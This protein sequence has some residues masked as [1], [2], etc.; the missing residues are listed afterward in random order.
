MLEQ[1]RKQ[2]ASIFVYLI[3]CLLIAIFVI[4]FR[5]G[6]SRNDDSGCSGTSN[7][8]LSVDGTEST[9]TAFKMAYSSPYNYGT[10]KSKVFIALETL[11]RR[12]LLA[13][14]GEARGLM[15]NEDLIMEQIKKGRFF[16][17]TPPPLNSPADVEAVYRPIRKAIPGVFNADDGHWDLKAYKT[18][19][20]NLN[21]SQNAY[22]EEQRRSMLAS[23]MADILME[24]VQVSKE[25]ALAQFRYDNDTATYD[26]VSFKP[27]TYRTALRMTETDVDRYL[28]DHGDDVSARYK[29]DERTYKGTK[30]ALKLR[31]IFIAAPEKTAEAPK[32]SADDKKPADKKPDDKKPADKTADKKDDKKDDKKPADKTPAVKPVGMPI[33]EAK[34]KLEA[35]R[36]AAAANKQKFADAA[37]QLNTDENAKTV[38]GD[39]GWHTI[40]NA[41]LGD[42]AVNDAVKALKPGAVTP[43]I[44]TDKGVFLIMADDKREGDLTFEQV[45]REIGWEMA[46]DAYSKEAAKRAA[47]AALTAAQGKKL[48]DL[49]DKAPSTAPGGMD[50]EQMLEDPNVPEATKAKIRQ[51][52]KQPQH[53]AL[54]VPEKDTPAGWFEAQDKAGSAAAGSATPLAGSGAVTG[55][56]APT[57]PV[58]TG[59]AAT[60]SAAGS[61]SAGAPP[62]TPVTPPADLTPSKDQLPAMSE[63]EKPHVE[64]F[65]PRARA[66]QISGL[67]QSKAAIAA[68]FEDLHAGDLAKK[69][70]EAEGAFVVVQ[71]VDRRQPDVKEFDK[72]ADRRVAELRT[73]RAQAFLDE[74]MRD[75]CEALAKDNKIKPNPEL[76][77]EH[78][79]NG[80]LLPVTY[81]PCMSF[82]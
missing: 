61:G 72:D 60:G 34:A 33:D 76:L 9:Q 52:M 14:E 65:G 55:T 47:L 48:A 17:A 4:N 77:V 45:K 12:E 5:P 18:W 53:G 7:V 13:N 75:R 38:A 56:G 6:Q 1:M 3:F 46:K 80:K 74:W 67:G 24:G 44:A 29:A 58:H 69:V 19:V 20:A 26:V 57:T 71:L 51:F 32:G 50:L 23:M 66:N 21:I 49:Y 36:T 59:S 64:R 40:D 30:P 82:H 42:K 22:I 10:Q 11:I 35:V 31:Q 41:A 28:K 63:I 54:E 8:V 79:D 15:V 27:E 68:V 39:I 70:Y 16:S 73:A 25:E 37:K 43:V 81:R 62:T 78:D 2:G